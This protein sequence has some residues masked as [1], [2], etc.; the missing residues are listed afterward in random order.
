MDLGSRLIAVAM[1]LS[2]SLSALAQP[3]PI[4][5]GT[6]NVA[7]EARYMAMADTPGSGPYPAVKELDSAFP[8]HVVYRPRDLLDSAPQ[9][10]RLKATRKAGLARALVAISML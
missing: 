9:E 8:G 1:L 6:S 7:A 3:T 10:D 5:P 4:D 2:L